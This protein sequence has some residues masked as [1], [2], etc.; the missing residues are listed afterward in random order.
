M[1]QRVR[2]NRADV[3]SHTCTV[4]TGRS[5]GSVTLPVSRAA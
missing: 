5:A 4:T 3:T 1:C 2:G